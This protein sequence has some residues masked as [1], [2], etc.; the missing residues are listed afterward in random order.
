MFADHRRHVVCRHHGVS[1]LR[2]VA[3]HLHVVAS[4]RLVA[5]RFRLVVSCP[6]VVL[7]HRS[8]LFH[9]VHH[10]RPT[11]P[12]IVAQL[13]QSAIPTNAAESLKSVA[14]PH[15]HREPNTA[16]MSHAAA[17]N[18]LARRFHETSRIEAAALPATLLAV[19]ISQTRSQCRV[20]TTASTRTTLAPVWHPTMARA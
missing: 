2:V 20:S 6:P 11:S 13:R 17:G 18:L 5:G 15:R 7:R 19:S 10:R 8:E 16:E 14:R 4:H 1:H 12:A 9:H 3:S